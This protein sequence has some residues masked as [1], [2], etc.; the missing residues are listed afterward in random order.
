[1]NDDDEEV[2]RLIAEEF[3]RWEALP[4]ERRRAEALASNALLDG[5]LQPLVEYIRAG[6]PIEGILAEQL[7]DAI[8]GPD[9]EGFTLRM[10]NRRRGHRKLS[11]RIAQ[12]DRNANI[13]LFV[14]MSQIDDLRAGKDGTYESILRLAGTKYGVGRTTVTDAVAALR[15]D[16]GDDVW[17]HQSLEDECERLSRRSPE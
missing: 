15:A 1:M 2:A 17:F 13:A 7:A 11:D 4:L 6:W 3:A 12:D 9:D 10:I 14:R 16:L 5:D 8:E